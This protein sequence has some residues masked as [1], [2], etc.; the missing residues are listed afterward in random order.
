[1]TLL[2]SPAG[3]SA[4]VG[5]GGGGR[6]RVRNHAAPGARHAERRHAGAADGLQL[7]AVPHGEG[8]QAEGRHPGAPRRP[9]AGRRAPGARLRPSLPL[10]L[11]G[12]HR[13]RQPRRA[14]VPEVRTRPRQSSADVC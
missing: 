2:F 7:R 5:G 13:R 4:G 6:G 9:P 11:Q 3:S 8:A 10:H 14:A 1:M 12:L